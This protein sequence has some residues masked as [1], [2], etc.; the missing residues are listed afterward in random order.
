[1]ISQILEYV[2]KFRDVFET[3][4]IDLF[5]SVVINIIVAIVL[6]KLTDIFIAKL[7]TH[8]KNSDNQS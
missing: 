3:L 4:K 5:L 6:F 7:K 1:M 2:G 8:S